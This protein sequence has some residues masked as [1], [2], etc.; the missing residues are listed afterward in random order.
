MLGGV[1]MEIRGL[2]STGSC[3]LGGGSKDSDLL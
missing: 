1:A 3:P 2:K